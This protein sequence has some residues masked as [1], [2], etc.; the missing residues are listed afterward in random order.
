MTNQPACQKGEDASEP[1]VKTCQFAV[2]VFGF[3]FRVFGSVWTYPVLVCVWFS[4]DISRPGLVFWF[5][6]VLVWGFASAGVCRPPSLWSFA[7]LFGVVW[8][9]RKSET[10]L[11]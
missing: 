6:S 11:T 3:W 10:I 2:F 5:V 1:F 7:P 8:E 4:L 9:N